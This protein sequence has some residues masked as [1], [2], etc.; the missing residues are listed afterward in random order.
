MKGMRIV[1]A[2]V[3]LSLGGCGSGSIQSP[4]FTRELGALQ[5]VPST[6]GPDQRNAAGKLPAGAS[7]QLE[8]QGKYT[9]PPDGALEADFEKVE[10]AWSSSV[11]AVA[12]V[13]SSKGLVTAVAEGT[14]VITASKNG[15][16]ATFTVNVGAA[17]MASMI[18]VDPA[19]S[20]Q[21][22]VTSKTLA[23]GASQDYL[24]L[25]V[26]TD[27]SVRSITTVITFS[28]SDESIA[29][30]SVALSACGPTTVGERTS[31]D[32]VKI[33][34][35]VTITATTPKPGSTTPFSATTQLTVGD[36]ALR[37]GT[38]TIS[39][40]GANV[41]PGDSQDFDVHGTFTDGTVQKIDGQ[42][43]FTSSAPSVATF[44]NASDLAAGIVTAVAN[45]DATITATLKA[46]VSP[47][48]ENRSV[49]ATV[50]VTDSVCT[51]ELLASSGATTAIP[52]DP[53]I[54]LG[55]GVQNPD[56]V[57]DAIADNFAS[58][59]VP[60]G[61]LDGA[62]KLNVIKGT[63]TTSF[64]AGETAGFIIGQPAG[65]LALASL[66]SQ[67]QVN[68]LNNGA[69][70][71]GTDDRIVLRVDLLGQKIIDGTPND[72]ALVSFKTSLPYNGVQ[73][74]LKSG[75]V[76]ALT[77]VQAYSACGTT[78]PPNPIPALTA[79]T[80]VEPGTASIEVGKA[81]G[82]TAQGLFADGTTGPIPDN[83]LEWTSSSST[84]TD[85][86]AAKGVFNGKAAGTATITAKLR[87]NIPSGVTQRSATAT[88]T[89][90]TPLC[91][92][93]LV[94][95]ASHPVTVEHGFAGLC[96]F[97]SVTDDINL[98]DATT[99]NFA[100]ISLNLAALGASAHVDVQSG[101]TTDFVA[102]TRPGFV[103]GEPV[104]SVA[105]AQILAGLQISTLAAD[106]TVLESSSDSIPLRLDLL[107]IEIIPNA[108][109]ALVSF[110]ATQPYRGLRLTANAGVASL[111]TEFQA[112][113]ACAAT[114]LPATAP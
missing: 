16:D 47:E 32:A 96:V 38:L 3:A 94:A 102:G 33:G 104:G 114:T 105:L 111:L 51:D 97:C 67:I 101:A 85:A 29:C 73:L 62:A 13:D 10:A 93:P 83:Y 112:Y 69:V 56:F 89:V 74:A 26:Y 90:T 64:T 109:T 113:S 30:L 80:S 6:A 72:L 1:A 23:L 7:L 46:G 40:T 107:G 98:I 99:S 35:P 39:P 78:Q 60:V 45:G 9:T 70:Q 68:T 52:A 12:T 58:L 49:T 53:S 50:H 61:L 92:V 66:L 11:P 31:A 17:E 95:D 22:P 54:C 18:I 24:A 76:S 71:E 79:L 41:R 43:D 42:V 48:I 84:V 81:Q 110:A 88:L 4:D 57:I 15:I 20:T 106:G 82:F 108:N 19:D 91:T 75:T 5:I 63:P 77:S 34:G 65:S 86:T 55:C 44:A 28:T 87:D 14:T 103:V 36:A 37:D 8:A 100:T 27:K 2:L 25:A 59:N 21:T